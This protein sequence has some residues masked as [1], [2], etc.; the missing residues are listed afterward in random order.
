MHLTYTIDMRS[1]HGHNPGTSSPLDTPRGLR[2]G[3]VFLELQRLRD[4]ARPRS[5]M[6]TSY[7]IHKVRVIHYNGAMRVP[8]E[9]ALSSASDTF[10]RRGGIVRTGDAVAAGVHYSTLYWMRDA[11]LLD[12]LGRGLYRLAD[13]PP[14]TDQDLVIVSAR[15]PGAVVCL[16]SALA[17]HQVGTQ[18]P[19]VVSVALPPKAWTP[20]VDHPPVQVYRM[21][22]A[23]LTQGAQKH[24]VDGLPVMVFGIAKT[25]A[26]C[27]KFRNKIGLEV[28][29][30]ALQEVLRSKKATPAEIM[31][32]AQVDRVANIIRPYLEA[33]Q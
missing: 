26:D 4:E 1:K 9:R 27:F 19:H 15:I 17:F 24:T 20:R 13:L 30:E 12:T 22:G 8:S 21:S 2:R 28:A 18:I 11:G 7:T 14:L 29:V 10:R 31:E 16:V 25:I 6:K 32:C 23:A 3:I 5:V 33:L